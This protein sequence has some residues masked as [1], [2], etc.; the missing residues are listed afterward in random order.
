VIPFACHDALT[1]PHKE[2]AER[3]LMLCSYSEVLNMPPNATCR[4]LPELPPVLPP[5]PQL[6]VHK[7]AEA[8]SLKTAETQGRSEAYWELVT[9]D[10]D[11]PAQDGEGSLASFV[12]TWEFAFRARFPAYTLS[13]VV[14]DVC[15]GA[16]AGKDKIQG[17]LGGEYPLTMMEHVLTSLRLNRSVDAFLFVSNQWV[18]PWKTAWGTGP[19][20]IVNVLDEMLQMIP[21]EASLRQG[22]HLG[23]FL[24]AINGAQDG[25]D[26]Q[27]AVCLQYERLINIK[28]MATRKMAAPFAFA[29]SMH[30]LR[31]GS[32]HELEAAIG[33]RNSHFS[34]WQQGFNFFLALLARFADDSEVG[35]SQFLVPPE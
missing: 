12:Q 23:R 16:V 28:C 30:L 5:S 29:V 1:N 6:T 34:S 35:A 11:M 17:E 21:G 15:K 3:E 10:C 18:T 7:A 20:H 22:S 32:L 25:P 26:G 27:E 8:E 19:R 14:Y 2:P 24:L 33:F 13:V 31:S 9:W 4:F